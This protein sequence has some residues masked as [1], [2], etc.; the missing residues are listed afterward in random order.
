M[1]AS[2]CGTRW[3]LLL[4]DSR[5]KLSGQVSD[6]FGLSGIRMVR[7]IAQGATDPAEIAALA[8]PG[9]H[10]SPEQL[11]DALAAPTTLSPQHRQIL[12]PFLDRLE[13][14]WGSIRRSRLS[15]K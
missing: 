2:G 11:A 15:R 4:E 13:L 3:S 1:T 5:I 14:A 12:R 9:R 6:L 7:A 8:V 10:A